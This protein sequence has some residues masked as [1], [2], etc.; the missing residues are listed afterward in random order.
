MPASTIAGSNNE[1]C[2]ESEQIEIEPKIDYDELPSPSPPIHPNSVVQQQQQNPAISRALALKS[3]PTMALAS[4]ALKM[5][6]N[7]PDT[8]EE[9]SYMEREF[10]EQELHLERMHE[11]FI[12]QQH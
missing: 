8:D 5:Q 7:N 11:Y 2:N 1:S 6:H 4:G 10:Q 9:T 12:Q 3:T